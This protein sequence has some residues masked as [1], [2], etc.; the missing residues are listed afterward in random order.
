MAKVAQLA[1][2]DICLYCRRH[3]L[4]ID[5]DSENAQLALKAIDPL[6]AYGNAKDPVCIYVRIV[7]TAMHSHM[8]WD[9]E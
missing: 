6:D 3:R 1:K 5:L 9:F 7:W 8:N 4:K 2:L